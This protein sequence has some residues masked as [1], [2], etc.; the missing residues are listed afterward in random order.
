MTKTVLKIEGEAA[1]HYRVVE[2]GTCPTCGNDRDGW[3]E[4]GVKFPKSELEN[5]T[6][7][8]LR[9]EV[10]IAESELRLIGL[11]PILMLDYGHWY[12]EALVVKALDTALGGCDTEQLNAARVLVRDWFEAETEASAA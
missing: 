7:Y 1:E 6:T 10:Q 9:D 3:V 11:V 4:L 12:D 5:G 2:N 8:R